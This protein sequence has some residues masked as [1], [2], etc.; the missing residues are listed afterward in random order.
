MIL[1]FLLI[2]IVMTCVGKIVGQEVFDNR[3]FK[4]EKYRS[5]KQLEEAARL[6]FSIGSN[7]DKIVDELKK[8]GA[9]CYTFNPSD[10][11]KPYE[12]IISCEYNA[13]FI[14]LHPFEWYRIALCIDKDHKLIELETHRVEGLTLIIP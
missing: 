3:P 9:E 13:K 7:V 1:K 2:F 6:K 8:S 4:F 10:S 12:I 11:S 14:S 5:N